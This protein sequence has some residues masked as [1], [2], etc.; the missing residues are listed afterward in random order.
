M[1][2][3]GS[4]DGGAS[5]RLDCM[6]VKA[7]VNHS[8]CEQSFANITAEIGPH[9]V[10]KSAVASAVRRGET[11]SAIKNYEKAIELE[12]KNTIAL[13]SRG[14]EAQE[15]GEFDTAKNF[16][17]RTLKIDP[18][19]PEGYYGMAAACE[20]LGLHALVI[21]HTSAFLRLSPDSQMKTEAQDMIDVATRE[22]DS[23]R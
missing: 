12:P 3:I 23:E 14:L 8:G 7:A 6:F 1:R 9:R 10:R 5:Q 2:L 11:E 21:E 13:Y 16:Y 19:S 17:E 22:L 4:A 20:G 15:L 18:K